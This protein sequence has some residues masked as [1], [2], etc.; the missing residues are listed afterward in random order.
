MMKHEGAILTH[1]QYSVSR[2]IQIIKS[3]RRRYCLLGMLLGKPGVN[4]KHYD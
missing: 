2:E 1:T 3:H 4:T